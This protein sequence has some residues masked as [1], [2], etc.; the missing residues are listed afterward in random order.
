MSMSHSGAQIL[1][2]VPLPNNDRLQL[3]ITLEPKLAEL[4]TPSTAFTADDE[5]VAVFNL[6]L[7]ARRDEVIKALLAKYGLPRYR[8]LDIVI[9]H[10]QAEENVTE[11]HSFLKQY[12]A[13]RRVSGGQVHFHIG[14]KSQNFLQ[15]MSWEFVQG[16]RSTVARAAIEFVCR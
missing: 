13:P 10:V 15:G 12:Q 1:A 3:V 16:N 4:E 8:L 5:H 7:G 14:S 9:D 11:F 6:Q 2:R